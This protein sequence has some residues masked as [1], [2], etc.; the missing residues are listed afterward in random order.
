MRQPRMSDTSRA[1]SPVRSS[2]GSD[3]PLVELASS[4]YRP[5]REGTPCRSRRTSTGLTRGRRSADLTLGH[6][7]RA[8]FVQRLGGLPNIRLR[9]RL[10]P[11]LQQLREGE[12]AVGT[13]SI[14]PDTS[15]DTIRTRQ[16]FRVSAEVFYGGDEGLRSPLATYHEL[17][18]CRS[19]RGEGS[20]IGC[21]VSDSSNS[22]GRARPAARQAAVSCLYPVC[23]AALIGF[24]G[25]RL[26]RGRA[27]GCFC[28]GK[29][30]EGFPT[31]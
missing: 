18:K 22:A 2:D 30:L 13:A 26:V 29:L 20:R 16:M 25:R 9:K 14:A 28:E 6:V 5:G 10:L 7:H 15:A 23:R 17:S 19:W 31:N 12:A 24:R 1:P 8:D 11:A 4:P 3:Y 27:D 21:G